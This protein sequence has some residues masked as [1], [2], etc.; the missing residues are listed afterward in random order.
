MT[1]SK[2]SIDQE[3]LSQGHLEE[4]ESRGSADSHAKQATGEVLGKGHAEEVE[5][6]P[7]TRTLIGELT[8]IIPSQE[9]DKTE[10]DRDQSIDALVVQLLWCI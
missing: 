6:C 7:D 3:V 10:D 8:L 5:K 9:K 1:N 4:K 2:G